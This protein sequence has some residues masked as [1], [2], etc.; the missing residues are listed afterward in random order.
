MYDLQ[1]LLKDIKVTQKD[2][3]EMVGV[4]ETAISRVK[5]GS[6]VM[7]NDWLYI[8]EEKYNLDLRKYL[9][10]YQPLKTI[11]EDPN[12]KE[13]PF[14]N[15]E[16]YGTISPVLD[17]YITMQPYAIKKNTNVHVCRWGSPG[18]RPLNENTFGHLIIH[19]KGAHW[20]Y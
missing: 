16:V 11:P 2:F 8:I 18:Q 14:F 19:L 15:Q 20:F 13:I 10:P 6:M 4:S 12:G 5:N 9:L 17:D 7:P 1:R 3:S